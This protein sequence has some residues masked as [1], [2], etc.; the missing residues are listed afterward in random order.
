MME[1][2]SNGKVTGVRGRGGLAGLLLDG[3]GEASEQVCGDPKTC[4][5][6]SLGVAEAPLDEDLPVC[7]DPKTCPQPVAPTAPDLQ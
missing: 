6:P 2:M 5:Q 4:P 1:S 7:G 3:G